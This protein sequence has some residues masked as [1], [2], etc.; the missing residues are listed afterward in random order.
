MNNMCDYKSAT[1]SISTEHNRLVTPEIQKAL[2][3]YPLYSQDSKG[4]DAVCVAV[5]YLG[6]MR[7]YI[8]EGQQEGSDFTFYGIV[9]GLYE[10]EYGYISANELASITYDARKYVRGTEPRR[11]HSWCNPPPCRGSSLGYTRRRSTYPSSGMC[12]YSHKRF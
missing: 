5:F 8:L 4:K 12:Q 3:A 6:S 11:T 2:A 10:T 7:W 1:R 9:A